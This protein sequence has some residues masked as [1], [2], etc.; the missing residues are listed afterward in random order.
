VRLVDERERADAERAISKGSHV[1]KR[2]DLGVLALLAGAELIGTVLLIHD[3]SATSGLWPGH[4]WVQGL[5]FLAVFATVY[6]LPSIIANLRWHH[7]RAS[8]SLL[9]VLLGWT[10]LGWMIALIWSVIWVPS[11]ARRL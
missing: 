4:G 5:F 11:T 8:I 2:S 9:N 6:A 10:V 7:N 3:D 1:M